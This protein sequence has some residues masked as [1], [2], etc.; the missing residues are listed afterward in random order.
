MRT[1]YKN[2]LEK[3]PFLDPLS[4]SFCLDSSSS[5]S[6]HSSR[7][8]ASLFPAYF[9][10]PPQNL[11]QKTFGGPPGF[12]DQSQ[13]ISEADNA[14]SAGSRLEEEEEVPIMAMPLGPRREEE[15]A[16]ALP[17]TITGGEWGASAA[18]AQRLMYT[19]RS[20]SSKEASSGLGLLGGDLGLEETKKT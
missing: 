4:C 18:E 13:I 16:A 7:T 14:T 12:E 8:A 1:V 19:L 2:R 6:S 15:T 9:E 3:M 17:W 5:S 20:S 10:P 11:R